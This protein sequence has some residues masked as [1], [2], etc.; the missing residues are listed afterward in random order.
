MIKND[1]DIQAEIDCKISHLLSINEK[2]KLGK[3]DSLDK[4]II[5]SELFEIVHKWGF[6]TLPLRIL[7]ELD[8][9][10]TRVVNNQSDYIRIQK[11]AQHET[12]WRKQR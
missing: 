8:L 3:L 10:L 11:E 9:R 7:H 12:N 2:F 1:K 5:A 4:A 6:H